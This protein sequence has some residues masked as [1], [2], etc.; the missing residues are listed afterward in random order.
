[1]KKNIILFIIFTLLFT[2][3]SSI[4]YASDNDKVIFVN[5]E[6]IEIQEYVTYE[7]IDGEKVYYPA[8]TYGDLFLAYEDLNYTY[9]KAKETYQQEIK[10][11][12]K[13]IE[14][15]SKIEADLKFQNETI[16]KE[17]EE[18]K[19]DSKQEKDTHYIKNIIIVIE[20]VIIICISIKSK[21]ITPF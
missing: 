13:Q 1:M 17:Q 5:P 3:L 7:E 14:K 8:S 16:L 11:L 10:D 20:T 9:E 6:D 21:P 12:N 18:N 2:L 4:I 19:T 15:L